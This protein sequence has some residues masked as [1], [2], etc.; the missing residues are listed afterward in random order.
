MT[1]HIDAIAHPLRQQ[2][3][4]DVDADVLVVEQRPGRAQQEDDAKQNPLQLEPGI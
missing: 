2:V 1:D 4:H 3:I